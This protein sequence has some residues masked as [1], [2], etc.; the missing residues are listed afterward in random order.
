[1]AAPDFRPKGVVK[2]WSLATGRLF[3]D[4]TISMT[5]ALALAV[6]VVVFVLF[7]TAHVLRFCFARHAV[8]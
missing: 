8:R 2:V 4:A 5:S 6:G 1:M 7:P 3:P